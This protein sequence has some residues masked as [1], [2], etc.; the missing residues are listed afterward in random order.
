MVDRHGLPQ[1]PHYRH[2]V[3]PQLSSAYTLPNSVI[4]SIA[5]KTSDTDAATATACALLP[6]GCA[7]D[8][9][10]VVLYPSTDSTGAAAVQPAIGTFPLPLD[11]YRNATQ[12]LFYSDG[13]ATGTFRLDT[14]GGYGT[15]QPA[16]QFT[17][18]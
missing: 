18:N 7:F 15:L 14:G 16:V 11:T 9:L 8:S 13:G 3:R 10:N 2:H 12:S 5:F 1:R 4:V 17:A 6:N